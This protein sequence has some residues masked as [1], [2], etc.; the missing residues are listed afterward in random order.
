MYDYVSEMSISQWSKKCAS[1]FCREPANVNRQ[2][3]KKPKHA[4]LIHTWSDKPISIQ[5]PRNYAY[6]IDLKPRAILYQNIP[7]QIGAWQ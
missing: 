7:I 6:L 2:S 1:H 3:I 5:G 4:N